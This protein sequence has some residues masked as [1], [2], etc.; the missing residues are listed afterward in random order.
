MKFGVPWFRLR[1][2]TV[3]P[4]SQSI[5]RDIGNIVA[6]A[7]VHLPKLGR[8]VPVTCVQCEPM[9]ASDS[10]FERDSKFGV[11]QNSEKISKLRASEF[12]IIWK[13]TNHICDV[14]YQFF[15]LEFFRNF[16]DIY[17]RLFYYSWPTLWKPA[18]HGPHCESQ[19]YRCIRVS[20][21]RYCRGSPASLI[22]T[23]RSPLI[24]S[25]TPL[26]YCRAMWQLSSPE[27]SSRPRLWL[28]TL[29]L[30]GTRELMWCYTRQLRIWRVR[31]RMRLPVRMRLLVPHSTQ[32]A[33]SW[34]WIREGRSRGLL[35]VVEA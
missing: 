22:R 10:K 6:I 3:V 18:S 19:R 15:L 1:H 25:S 23:S 13:C 34:R 7:V 27:S 21:L 12:Q 28:A 14:I 26:W 30:A 24:S 16:L 17:F 11:A 8:V 33:S 5:T 4:E 31:W 20:G 32:Q 2:T 9:R 29:A 35:P